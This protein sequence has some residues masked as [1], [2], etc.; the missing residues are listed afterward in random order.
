MQ[1]KTKKTYSENFMN[2][3]NYI[4]GKKTKNNL[5]SKFIIENNINYFFYVINL[6]N[7]A[8]NSKKLLWFIFIII[9][10]FL[11]ILKASFDIFVFFF[12]IVYAIIFMYKGYDEI[13]NFR[14]LFIPEKL[15]YIL[16]SFKFIILLI[17]FIVYYGT[18][19]YSSIILFFLWF[20]ST[21]FIATLN[22][23]NTILFIITFPI[24]FIKWGLTYIYNFLFKWYNNYL[25]IQQKPNSKILEKFE[26]LEEN[27]AKNKYYEIRPKK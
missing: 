3:Q 1:I 23:W 25:I 20:I 10:F 14:L 9:I 7:K 27:Y 16:Y 6:I 15:N 24:L 26:I 11:I 5:L 8:F 19:E 4:L 21:V 22:F 18:Q 13:D 17:L 12:L 2:S